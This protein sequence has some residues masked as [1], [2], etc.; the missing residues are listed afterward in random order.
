MKARDSSL[1]ICAAWCTCQPQHKHKS[2]AN[3]NFCQASAHRGGR[4]Q[5]DRTPS[6]PSIKTAWSLL[7]LTLLPKCENVCLCRPL[8]RLN[9]MSWL[10]PN[11][12]MEHLRLRL[13]GDAVN[14]SAAGNALQETAHKARGLAA[15]SRS[16]GNIWELEV[17]RDIAW[18]TPEPIAASP[19]AK[20]APMADSAGIQTAPPCFK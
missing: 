4:P 14:A 15:K 13:T 19:M 5:P 3:P 18:P 10:V 11:D 20:P 7:T 2:S 1:R 12:V 9:K 6:H 17:S 16:S 8:L